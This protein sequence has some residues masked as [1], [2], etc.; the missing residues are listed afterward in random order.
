MNSKKNILLKITGELLLASDK[1]SENSLLIRSLA[2]QIKALASSHYFAIVIGGGNF[3]RGNNQGKALGITSN[4]SHYVGMFATIMNGLLIT[5][6]FQ[7][8][9]LITTLLSALSIPEVGL[10]ISP[11]TIECA[12]RTTNTIVFAGGT[13]NPFFTTDTAAILRGLQIKADE[14]W[15]GTIVD[16][17]YDADPKKVLHAQQIKKISHQEV[18]NKNLAFMDTTA[19]TLAQEHCMPIRVFNIFQPNALITAASDISFGSIVITNS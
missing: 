11:H 15:K 4:T 16:A 9:G 7:Q 19:I 1:Q 8:E 2:Q 12:M 3:F 17:I 13:G 6:I 10:P 5:D 14:V 18:L